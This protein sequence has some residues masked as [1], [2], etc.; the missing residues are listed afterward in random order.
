MHRIFAMCLEAGVAAV[1]LVPVFLIVNR[2]YFHNLNQ[3]IGYLLFAIYLAAVDAVVGLPCVSYIRL[4]FNFNF[5]PFLY[6]FSDYKN[7]LLNVLLFV[8]LGFFLPFFWKKFSSFGYT[9][10]FGFCTSLHIE[11]LQIFTLRAT[12]VNDLITNTFGTVLGY[13]LARILL[14][15][16]PEAAPSARTRDVF[17]VCG[18]VFGVMFFLQ[19]FLAELVWS[20]LF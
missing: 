17:L 20:L 8:P 12:D 19:P 11:L 4:D 14:K 18:I 6:M 16:L 3:T 2:L 5:T 9:V 1:V 10:L 13:L 15:L 7:S